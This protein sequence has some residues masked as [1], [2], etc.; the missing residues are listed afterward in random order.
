[1]TILD[2]SGS[3]S[4]AY[5]RPGGT[6]FR[7]A[8]EHQDEILR[9]FAEGDAVPASFPHTILVPGVW[10]DQPESFSGEDTAVNP[11]YAP[12]RFPMPRTPDAS[13]PYIVGTVWYRRSFTAGEPCSH[14]VLELDSVMTRARVWVNGACA[15]CVRGYSAPHTVSLDGFLRAGENELII[16]VTNDPDMHLGCHVR[17]YKGFSGELGAVSLRLTGAC[18]I[19]DAAGFARDEKFFTI[20]ALLE[21]DTEGAE[22]GYKVMDGLH[23]V[24]EGSFPVEGLSLR[25]DIL[26]MGLAPW[27]DITPKLYELRLVLRSKDGV[28]DRRTL[29]LGLRTLRAH[30]TQLTLNSSPIFLRGSTEHAYYP[31]TCT[32]PRDARTYAKN[33]RVLRSL[34]F[35]FLRFHTSVPC[36]GCLQAADELG[37]L[38]QL[39]APVGCT[40]REWEEILRFVRRHPSAAIACGGNEQLLDEERI[41]ELAADA[42]VT[43]ELAPAL[44]YNPHEAL[45][46][47]EYGWSDSDMGECTSEPFPHNP[48]RLA[49]LKRFSDVF[50]QYS[51][52]FLSYDSAEGDCA[53]LDRRLTVYER[54]CLS[55]EMGIYGSYIDLSLEPRYS[56]TRIGADLYRG[57]REYMEHE[58]MLD[59]ARTFYENSCALV[60]SIRKH[61][62]ETAR[63][64]RRLAGFDYLGVIDYHWHRTGYPCGILNEFYEEKPHETA[65]EVLLWNSPTVLLWDHHNRFTYDAGETVSCA[66]L[67]SRY[68]S[69][70]LA[71]GTLSWELLSSSGRLEASG[72]LVSEEIPEGSV[73]QA[74][75]FSVTL[76]RCTGAHTLSVVLES[77]GVTLRNHWK[78]WSFAAAENEPIPENVRAVPEL[79]PEGLEYVLGG[80]RLLVNSARP[81]PAEKTMF[82][83]VPAGRPFGATGTVVHPHPALADFPHE[84]WCDWQWKSLLDS[85]EAIRFGTPASPT[86]D[87]AFAPVVEVISGFKNLDR[88]SALS[89]YD[90]GAGRLMLC[91]LRFGVSPEQRALK[92]ALVRYLAGTLQPAP[93]LDADLLRARMA[94]TEQASDHL[95]TDR[96]F[97]ENAQAG[98]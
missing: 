81:L 11:D 62:V 36:E 32:P 94:C 42:R 76:P 30:G 6:D 85:G 58:G 91:G 29:P 17:G 33:L 77:C 98:S 71:R 14:A 52:G 44:L 63:K 60:A 2:L 54:P 43:H 16:A 20:D 8:D 39:E 93:A 61:N 47:V 50:G 97:D 27:S 31:E 34:G 78:L 7:F 96:G 35:N 65:S 88:L 12:V 56:G 21:G 15:G 3:W 49:A 95:E 40:P 83:P 26:S 90:V 55:H 70:S 4:C 28:C 80:G 53:E 69:G 66:M 18:R 13:L 64:C 45:R 48:Q 51:W 46:G 84:G 89:E 68:E 37:F 57:A 25:R 75:V 59:R 41:A 19:A 72:E 1:M 67:V 10:D 79:T 38:V 86:V 87:A 24:R 5:T 73:A 82:R 74:A 22:L 92:A 23:A 9:R